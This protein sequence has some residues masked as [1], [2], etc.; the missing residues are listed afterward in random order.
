MTG[1]AKKRFSYHP[2]AHGIAKENLKMAAQNAATFFS[3]R[4]RVQNID[5]NKKQNCQE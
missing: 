5:D 2:Y 4:K 1:K 3:Q